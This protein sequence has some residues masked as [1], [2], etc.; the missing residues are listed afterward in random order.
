MLTCVNADLY[1]Q[2]SV[3]LVPISL[4]CSSCLRPSTCNKSQL[5]DIKVAHF[6]VQLY[7]H[8]HDI[9]AVTLTHIMNCQTRFIIH[10]I[11]ALTANRNA[12]STPNL[13]YVVCPKELEKRGTQPPTSVPLQ[14]PEPWSR[15]Q[16]AAMQL[17]QRYNRWSC[18]RMW[19]L[20]FFCLKKV[21]LHS[22]RGGKERETIESIEADNVTNA[23][24]K[25]RF[26]YRPGQCWELFCSERGR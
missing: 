14:V 12:V 13:S 1:V 21:L 2:A 23:R 20:T 15:P 4:H 10:F 26:K 6:Y 24:L 5:N 25:L 18:V 19:F 16:E 3:H 11:F 22:Y 8:C 7:V 17:R 9:L